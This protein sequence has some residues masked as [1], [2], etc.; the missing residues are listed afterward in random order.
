MDLRVE[1]NHI[2]TQLNGIKIVD[3]TYEPAKYVDGQI[4]LQ[5]HTGM[6][7]FRIRFKDIQIRALP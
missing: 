7:G 4:G 3:Y 5:I 1:G 6:H 2:V